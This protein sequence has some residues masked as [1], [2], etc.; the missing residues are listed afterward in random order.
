MHQL[1]LFILR[2]LV[3]SC[4]QIYVGVTAEISQH[5]MMIQG[6]YCTFPHDLLS[7]PNAKPRVA[8]PLGS[9]LTGWKCGFAKVR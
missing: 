6:V 7:L 3:Q 2:I 1:S 8:T 4:F 9:I 5:F